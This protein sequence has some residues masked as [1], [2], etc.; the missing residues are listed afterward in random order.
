MLSITDPDPVKYKVKE[1]KPSK[2]S[3]KRENE[4]GRKRKRNAIEVPSADVEVFVVADKDTVAVHGNASVE[5]YILTMMNMVRN[6]PLSP[7]KT[8][9]LL[10]YGRRYHYDMIRT[11][12]I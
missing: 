1:S 10:S 6:I 11:L 8:C 2:A 3:G 7:I 4:T 9:P 5:G 12:L